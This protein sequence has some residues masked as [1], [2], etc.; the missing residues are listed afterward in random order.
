M[1]LFITTLFI[2]IFQFS[3]AS[4]I[5][6]ETTYPLFNAFLSQHVQHKKLNSQ[7]EERT[8][9]QYIKL[10]DPSKIYLLQSDV[11]KIK[12]DLSGLFEKVEKRECIAVEEA[13]QLFVKRVGEALEFTKKTLGSDFKFQEKTS[14]TKIG[15]AHV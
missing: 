6:C 5:G 4:Q 3:Q 11:D 13:H 12:Q 14:I 7:L 9:T 15:R 2:F 8:I 10:L 1:R